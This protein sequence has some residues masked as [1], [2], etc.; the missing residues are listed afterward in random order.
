VVEELDKTPAEELNWASSSLC[1]ECE[2]KDLADVL[3]QIFV[4]TKRRSLSSEKVVTPEPTPR[5]SG[6]DTCSSCASQ[7]EAAAV[8]EER[9]ISS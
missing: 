3:K 1:P 7:R 5:V 4:A 6:N 9:L 8:P 2:G